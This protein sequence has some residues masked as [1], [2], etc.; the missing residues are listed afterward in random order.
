MGGLSVVPEAF[1][2]VADDEDCRLLVVH[3]IEERP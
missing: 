1:A 2:V 3:R